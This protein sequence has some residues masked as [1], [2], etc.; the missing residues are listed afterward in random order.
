L[1][2]D[3]GVTQ[4]WPRIAP[5]GVAGIGAL[6]LA[7][8]LAGCLFTSES[9]VPS[10][11]LAT[12]A[13][14]T[15]ASP[16][17]SPS[18]LPGLSPTPSGPSSGATK[19]TPCPGTNRN[20]GAAAGRQFSGGSMNWAGYVSAVKK[21]GV[22]CVEGSWIQ[23]TVTCP[24][25]GHQAV[26]I[27]IGIDG[28]AANTLGIPSTDVLVQIGTQVTCTNGVAVHDAWHEILPGEPNE[29]PIAAVIHAGD[30]MSAKISYTDGRFTLVLFDADAEG[31]YSLTAAAP[32]APRKTAEWIVEAPST[33]CPGSCAPLPMPKFGS[34]RFTGAFVTI[35][36]QR[37]S[38]SDASW[39]T[40]KLKMVR[41]GVTRAT[42]SSLTS[43]GTSFRVAWKHS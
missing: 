10:D 30:H 36:G 40:V 29:V 20:P 26:A 14:S 22:T 1:A 35:A 5:G 25:T 12:G 3:A 41:T 9:P 16:G 27:W 38:I 11:A 19:P 21:T 42:V 34:V 7:A 2:H 39:S 32:G 23:P 43:G 15:P 8:T 6:L 17:A 28:F 31:L 13:A 18:A 33:D 24:R 37:S 4:R